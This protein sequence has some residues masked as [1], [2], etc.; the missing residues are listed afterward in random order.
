M[1]SKK[2]IV[3]GMTNWK[4]LVEIP[5][6]NL[7]EFINDQDSENNVNVGRL[8][9]TLYSDTKYPYSY[10]SLRDKVGDLGGIMIDEYH[11]W[12]GYVTD[13]DEEDLN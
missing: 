5:D 9:G 1:N 10:K 11:D 12:D 3:S 7:D 13:I 8:I 6:D 4:M 2:V